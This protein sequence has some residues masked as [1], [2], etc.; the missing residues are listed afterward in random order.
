MRDEE[1]A[2]RTEASLNI[3]LQ[4]YAKNV[5]KI[6]DDFKRV[7]E[8]IHQ[9]E[10]GVGVLQQGQIDQESFNH[11]ILAR[12]QEMETKIEAQ[13]ERIVSLEEEVAV[14]RWKKACMC[15]E[16]KEE[17]VVASGSGSQEDPIELEEE[18]LVYV[19]EEGSDSSY[20]SLLL[21]PG[22]PLL[23]F[24]EPAAEE[25][26]I[27]LLTSTCICPVPDVIRIEDDVEMTIAPRENPE[28]I[29]IRVE[30]PPRYAVGVQHAVR[31]QLVAHYSPMTRHINR[32]AK[33]LGT[34]NPQ[35]GSFMG[36]D[37]RFP[38]AR[39]LRAAVQ[40]TGRGSNQGSVGH[41]SGLSVNSSD[42]FGVTNRGSS[43]GSTVYSVDSTHYDPCASSCGG[44][45]L[46][47]PNGTC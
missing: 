15:R 36:Q 7:V 28:P 9:C 34:R 2:D 13:E 37:L 21:A 42:T 14:L 6:Q 39:E 8:K 18:R 23:V 41:A 25:A 24:G 31:R 26:P 3:H 11:A 22:S 46:D 16:K 4:Y 12:M 43:V 40:R 1:R 47:D 30:G 29:P 17:A 5:V 45:C 38:C 33:Q 10:D 32:H 27:L 44:D 20:H 19:E 35:L